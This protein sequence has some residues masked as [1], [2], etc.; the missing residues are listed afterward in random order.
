M[1]EP[2]PYLLGD[3]RRERA[4]MST[5]GSAT[6]RG[7]SPSRAATLAAAWVSSV[8]LAMAVWNLSSP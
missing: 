3:M 2:V 8:S 1:A 5:S 7:S 4:S 6:P